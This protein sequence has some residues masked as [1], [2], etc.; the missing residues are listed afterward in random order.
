MV[1]RHRS[2]AKGFFD[3]EIGKFVKPTDFDRA[4]NGLDLKHR[5]A[6]GKED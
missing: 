1:F 2:A 6:L 3:T 4:A 5:I